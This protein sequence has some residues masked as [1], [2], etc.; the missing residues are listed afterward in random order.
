MSLKNK[1]K[2]KKA[3]YC[4]QANEL[5]GVSKVAEEKQSLLQQLDDSV[6]VVDVGSITTTEVDTETATATNDCDCD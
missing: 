3:Q 1:L 5:L 6:E 2:E 4:Q